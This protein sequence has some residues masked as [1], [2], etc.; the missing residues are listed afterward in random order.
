M[1]AVILSERGTPS[2]FPMGK[3]DSRRQSN[4]VCL[5]RTTILLDDHLGERLR[6]QARLEGESFSAFLADAGLRALEERASTHAGTFRLITYC[7][8]GPYA[9]IDLDRPNELL[10][11][12]DETTYGEI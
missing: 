3:L 1:V 2:P 5:M 4:S 7:G 10:A 11:A 6:A 12:E 8:E 9:G